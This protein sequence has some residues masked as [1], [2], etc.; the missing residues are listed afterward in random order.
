VGSKSHI[1]KLESRVKD[2]EAT[3]KKQ[4]AELASFRKTVDGLRQSFAQ[5]AKQ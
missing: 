3:V 5:I 2:L 4:S 1:T